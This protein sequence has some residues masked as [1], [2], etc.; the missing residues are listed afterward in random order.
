MEEIKK[1]QYDARQNFQE[2]LQRLRPAD[3][4]YLS[5][6]LKRLLSG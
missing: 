4:Q 1:S 6:I 2:N 3:V 5:D